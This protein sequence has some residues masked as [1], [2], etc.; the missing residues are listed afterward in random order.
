MKI[1]NDYIEDSFI[2]RKLD[3]RGSLQDMNDFAYK[4]RDGEQV[5]VHMNFNPLYVPYAYLT[6]MLA[7]SMHKEIDFG[8]LLNK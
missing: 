7:D 6:V 3:V 2:M 8:S 5:T 4:L 1:F